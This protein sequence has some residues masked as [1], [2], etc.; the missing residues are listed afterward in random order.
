MPLPDML[1]TA[2]AAFAGTGRGLCSEWWDIGACQ[3]EAMD[4]DIPMEQV[5][6]V[7]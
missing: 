7:R 6:A 5:L 3:I 2:N 1:Y 4:G